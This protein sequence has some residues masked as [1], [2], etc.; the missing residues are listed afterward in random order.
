MKPIRI[1]LSPTRSRPVNMFLGM[2]LLLVSLLLFLA[3]ATYHATDP[4]LNTATDSGDTA[5]LDRS[6]RRLSRR[7]AAAVARP[8]G[9]S[10]SPLAGRRGLDL[11]ALAPR[12]L[13][14]PALDGNTP[15]AGL[16]ARGLWSAAVA[17]ALAAL[18]FRWKA[19]SAGWWPACWW[20]ISIFRAHGWWLLPLAAGG[21]YFASAISFWVIRESLA[22]RWAQNRAPWRD[23][24]ATAAKREAGDARRAVKLCAWSAMPPVPFPQFVTAEPVRRWKQSSRAASRTASSRSSRAGA[25]RNRIPLDEIPAYQRRAFTAGTG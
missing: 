5:Q 22:E 2:V 19:W 9:V 18:W 6:F 13:A 3:L 24:G 4:S 1:V 14:D 23:R 17:L 11:D 21:L 10:A 15:R 25:H 12:R 16:S 7:S 8:D 20:F